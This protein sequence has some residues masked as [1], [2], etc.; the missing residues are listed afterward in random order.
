M[1]QMGQWSDETE[2]WGNGLMAARCLIAPFVLASVVMAQQPTFRAG[3]AIVRI[4]V[5]VTD[6][7]G[8]AVHRPDEGRFSDLRSRQAADGRGARRNHARTAAAVAAS[9]TLKLDVADNATAKSDR[10][11]ILILDD[12]F[13]HTD[14]SDEIKAMAR[15]VIDGIGP[16]ASI[17]LVTTSGEFGI[18]P[19]EDRAQLLS[20]IDRFVDELRNPGAAHGARRQ[21]AA[22]ARARRRSGDTLRRPHRA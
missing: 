21:S 11:I 8:R 22:D 13:F 1:G 16:G 4:D 19:T 10:V 17:G 20:E 12:L 3:V 14:R 15:R 18:E 5:T 2:Q 6:G 7:R 9:A